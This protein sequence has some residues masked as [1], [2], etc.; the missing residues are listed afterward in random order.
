MSVGAL[1]GGNITLTA[2]NDIIN[3][4]A[5]I[6]TNARAAM[7][8]P[9]TSTLQEL[10]GGE[11]VVNAGRNIDAGIYYVECGMASLSAGG[12]ITTNSTRSPSLGII[13]N[14]NN[15]SASTLNSLTWLP[16]TLFLG[17]SSFNVSA[18]GD[19]LLGPAVNTFLLPQGLNNKFWYKTYFST[20]AADSS[21]TVTSTGGDVSLRYES[22]LPNSS[23]PNSI[24]VNWLQTQ[25]LFSTGSNTA[26]SIQP[27]L[28]LTET[29]VRE[30]PQVASLTAPKLFVT[31]L[32]GSL[33]LSGDLTLAPSPVGQ[34][35]LIASQGIN[36]L[37]PIG[38]SNSR[39]PE[40]QTTI[41]TA[42]TINVS[43]ANPESIPQALRPLSIF[44]L[45]GSGLSDNNT[46]QTGALQLFS[47]LFLESGSVIG[48][49][50]I[51][52]V[53]QDRHTPGL[54][55]LNDTEPVRI[56]TGS[57]DLSGLN[58]FTP[59]FTRIISGASISDVSLYIQNILSENLSVVSAAGSIL[60]STQTSPLRNLASATG[61]A[62]GF[63]EL[64][65][66]G[67]IQISGPGTLQ[68]IAG[69]TID[70]GL[71]A[72]LADGTGSGI[73]SIG[74]LR[75]PFLGEAGADLLLAA[76]LAPVG[77]N[78]LRW[79]KFIQ[80]FVTSTEGLELV[81][82]IRPG[83]NF[84]S[85]SEE[86]RRILAIQVFYRILRDTGRN[87]NDPDSPN[88]RSYEN[89]LKAIASLFG[90]DSTASRG[91][92][93]ARGRDIRTRSGGDIS[94][95][96][97]GGGLTLANTTLG[98]PLAPPGVITEA[99]G[100]I[101]IFTDQSVDIGIGRI[102]TLRGGDALIWSSNG[103]IAAGSSS[104]TVQS[105]PPTRVVIDPQS[106]AVQTDLAGL[107][108]GGGIGVL[109][110]VEGVEPGDVDLIAPTGLIDAGDAG[111]RVSGNINLA[112]VQVVNS[113]NISAGGTSSGGNATVSAPS[114]ST[115][116]AASN[117]SAATTAAAP[118]A[119][120]DKKEKP[121]EIVPELSIIDVVVIGY[122]G[123][124][125]PVDDDE[126]EE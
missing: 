61:N 67:D 25:N 14:L 94:L 16:T 118:A 4:D 59:K 96:A 90:E 106:A 82:D 111:I 80:E 92:I 81:E 99:G 35:E 79:E 21:V 66:A 104:R 78:S 68:I 55:H 73:T 93:F 8:R 123:G 58:L 95:L 51:S 85:L 122:G 11:L 125:S 50:A 20:Y 13:S 15:P 52:S 103:D 27:W 112:A 31:A 88:F 109:A 115:V 71:G 49:N 63:G 64:N 40:Q 100:S 41:W 72:G 29:N 56:Y 62:L 97:P 7:G 108:T 44:G 5:V 3:T 36:A 77:L 45:L 110:T 105:A 98:N 46:S 101:N 33:N 38:I 2:G 47:R 32:S 9:S 69:E 102:F 23:A 84:E 34:L 70:L 120:E 43:D 42:S 19:I 22:V 114:I 57:G 126:E 17:K 12:E 24:L 119:K 75:N 39:I 54:L 116:T 91:E 1:G 30:F 124:S 121:E 10:G 53:Q 37:S 60:A 6:P 107:A 86:E 74:N 117:T 87:Y 48:S 76:G 18:N 65:N 83:T 28:R 89:G 113:A 26:S